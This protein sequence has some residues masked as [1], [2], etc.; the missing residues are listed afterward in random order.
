MCVGELLGGLQAEKAG[1]GP[2]QILPGQ[3]QSLM[4]DQIA[5]LESSLAHTSSTP[6]RAPPYVVSSSLQILNRSPQYWLSGSVPSNTP[7]APAPQEDP[8]APP[9]VEVG[10]L[11]PWSGSGLC[12]G[13]Q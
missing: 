9:A 8:P 5:L 13:W 12:C 10:L 1:L 2:C 6:I 11:A 3:P 4:K 7:E